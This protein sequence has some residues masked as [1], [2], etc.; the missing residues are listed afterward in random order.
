[1]MQLSRDDELSTVF[2]MISGAPAQILHMPYGL[3]FGGPADIVVL[4]AT[5]PV[6]AIREIAP[7]LCGWKNGRKSFSR[8]APLLHRPTDA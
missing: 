1:V 6:S 2:S 4:D 7:A 8:P 3:G 5:D